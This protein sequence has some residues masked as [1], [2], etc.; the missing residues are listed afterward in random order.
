MSSFTVFLREQTFGRM[1]L[2]TADLGGRTVFVSGANRGL[3]YHATIHLARLNPARIILGVRDVNSGNKAAEQIRA[4][5]SFSGRIDV[6]PLDLSSFDSTIKCGKWCQL[7]ERIDI[8]LLNAGV[9]GAKF[10]K[11]GDGY[12]TMLQVNGLSTGLL[13]LLLLPKVASTPRVAGSNVKPHLTV[14]GSEVHSMASFKEKNIQGST[15]DALNDEKVANMLDRYNVS[16]VLSLFITRQLA[17]LPEAK[18]VVINVTNPGMC[19][20]TFRDEALPGVLAWLLN[21]LSRTTS[22]G[23]KNLAWAAV[24]NTTPPGAYISVCKV[25]EEAKWTTNESGLALEQKIWSEMT[26]IWTKLAPETASTL[27]LR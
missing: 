3:G 22:E 19:D 23:A 18:N 12:E 13:A 11:T 16:K 2:P 9:T 7:Q 1:I 17:K 24:E 14:V 26:E 5:T 20:T 25:A 8:A 21:K 6:T 15:I 4:E 27:R 10:V